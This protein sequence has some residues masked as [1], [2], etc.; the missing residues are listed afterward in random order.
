MGIKT[1]L[2][3]LTHNTSLIISLNVWNENVKLLV[4]EDPKTKRRDPTAP[5]PMLSTVL[6]IWDLLPPISTRNFKGGDSPVNNHFFKGGIDAE[7]Y[8][9]HILQLPIR[10]A[11]PTARVGGVSP[12]F[13]LAKMYFALIQHLVFKGGVTTA[14]SS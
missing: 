12:G 7:S 10:I 8:F 11:S 5:E 1:S 4:N 2:T 9:V 13:T 3:K 14:T 6:F